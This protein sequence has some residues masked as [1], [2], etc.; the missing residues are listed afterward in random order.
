MGS[1]GV[2]RDGICLQATVEQMTQDGSI[3]LTPTHSAQRACICKMHCRFALSAKNR[4]QRDIHIGRVNFTRAK[5]WIIFLWPGTVAP[6][7]QPQGYHT[8]TGDKV[9]WIYLFPLFVL[10]LSLVHPVLFLVWRAGELRYAVAAGSRC[11]TNSVLYLRRWVGIGNSFDGCQFRSIPLCFLGSNLLFW[12]LSLSCRWATPEYIASFAIGS[13]HRA[14]TDHQQLA[15][16]LLLD[17]PFDG[18]DV[19]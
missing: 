19:H 15:Q 17:K 18:F 8:N 1:T 3:M 7:H 16:E 12:F 9:R 14:N 11:F 4:L 10:F 5:T 13:M 2:M 6:P